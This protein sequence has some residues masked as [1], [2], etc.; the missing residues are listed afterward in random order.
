MPKAAMLAR[1][2]LSTDLSLKFN[3]A[4]P[5]INAKV[6]DPINYSDKILILQHTIATI[7]AL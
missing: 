1:E 3:M 5:Q 7:K 4:L 2:K 6:S